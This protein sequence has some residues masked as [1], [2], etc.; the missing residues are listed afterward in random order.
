MKVKSAKQNIGI[1]KFCGKEKKL[2]K[3]HI[4]PRHFHLNYENETYAAINSKTG[5]WKPC[6]TGTYDKNILCADCD[7]TI[8]KRFE[9]E[10]YR[11]LLNDIYNFAEYKYNQNILY[12]LTEK[13]FDYMLFRK[14]FISVLW[15]ASISKAEDFSNINLGPYE[16]IALKILESDIE[17]DNLFKILIF[18]FPRNMDNNSIVYL[19]KIKIKHETYCLCMAGYYIYIFI[20]EKNIPFDVIKYYGEFFLRKENIYILESPIFYQKHCEH[21]NTIWASSGKLYSY[22]KKKF[23]K[24]GY[25]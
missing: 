11:I 13:D 8:I 1:C 14:F 3:A 9:D 18:K 25:I 16:D 4:I 22:L 2:I 10:A 5:N 19:S 21:L 7:G 15:R 20:N 23:D 6:K 12:H 17:K 24:Y